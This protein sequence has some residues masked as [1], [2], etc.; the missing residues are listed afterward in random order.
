MIRLYSHSLPGLNEEYSSAEEYSC[1]SSL[2]EK[3]I[4]MDTLEQH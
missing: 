1:L 3:Y 4:M 2:L